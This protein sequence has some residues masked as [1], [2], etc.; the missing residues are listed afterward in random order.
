MILN[1]IGAPLTFAKRIRLWS[2]TNTQTTVIY[3]T[4]SVKQ[5]RRFRTWPHLS[6][7]VNDCYY[8]GRFVILFF[9]F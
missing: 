4:L 8:A 2:T 1:H 7:Q 3:S 6:L 9:N 5:A